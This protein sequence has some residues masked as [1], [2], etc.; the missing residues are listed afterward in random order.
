M[1]WWDSSDTLSKIQTGLA[2][3][4]S[5]LGVATLTEL[6]SDFLKK[7][8]DARRTAERAKLDQE[9]QEQTA[10]AL[11]ATREL[12]AKTRGRSV[13]DEQ[14]QKL[15]AGLKPAAGAPD[16]A[17]VYVSGDSEAESFATDIA[18]AFTQA[19]VVHLF[20]FWTGTPIPRGVSVL[21][22]SEASDAAAS[23]I[24]QALTGASVT[25]VYARGA[26]IPDKTISV[27]IGSKP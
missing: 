3:F 14:R 5:V 24:S 7:Q 1:N 17:I 23:L 8:S 21:S 26:F 11:R 19:G 20:T 6:R 2:V 18:G 15:T 9:L 16:I 22:R 27:L 10:T 4:I 25:N 12:E 13:S